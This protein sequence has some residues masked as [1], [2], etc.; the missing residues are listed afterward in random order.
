MT[1]R[2]LN[3]IVIA[4]P[5]E[6][7]VRFTILEIFPFSSETKRMGILVRNQKSDRLN[8]FLKGADVVLKEKLNLEERMFVQEEA[9][10]LS[11]EG[12]RTLV[13]AYKELSEQEYVTFKK[14]FLNAGKDIKNRDKNEREIIDKLEDNLT[15][16]GVT[17]VEDLLQENIKNTII[18]ISDAGIKVW[19]LTGDKLETAKC[20][21]ISTGFK[22]YF[23]KF[24]EINSINEVE[25]HNKIDL[26]DSSSQVLLIEGKSLE[27]I[28]KNQYL[29]EAF[30]KQALTAPSVVLCRCAPKQKAEVAQILKDEYEK[31]VCGIGDGGNDVGMIQSAN[32]GIGIEGKE[33]LQAS[34]ASD[35]SVMKFK[36]IL[37]LFL[38]HGRLSYV[39]TSLLSIFVIHRGLIITTIQVLFMMIFYYVSLNIYNGFLIL[40][41]STIFTSLPVF[42][43]IIDKDIPRHQ[44]FNYPQLYKLVQ[45]GKNLSVKIFFIW[46]WTSI[47]QGSAIMILSIKLFD[48][49]FVEIITITFTALIFIEFLNIYTAIRTWH[50]IITISLLSSALIYLFC[51][52][53]LRGLF[54]LSPL[55]SQDV[56]KII[57]LTVCAWL[58]L[59]LF[60][61]FKRAF[62][63][64]QIDKV[65][66]EAR[67]QEK[68]MRMRNLKNRT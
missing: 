4:T 37:Q 54:L 49:T 30:F 53:F 64:S 1:S 48:N 66:R 11:R 43:L 28:L 34:L 6:E 32:L 38:W 58:P 60:Q 63:P 41:Y 15:L 10:N 27:V 39:R 67:T 33:G 59:Q 56:I 62:F 22:K 18:N 68:R 2:T 35:F 17:A 52:V 45:D 51:L 57:V 9:Y 29:K 13:L 50:N 19:M 47:F 46:L 61:I 7:E 3:E 12:L 31:V 42:A 55:T 26:Y 65:V 14:Q 21:A 40:C 44:A 25:L 20:I 8:F 5:H 16:L 23:Q 24:H 36:Y